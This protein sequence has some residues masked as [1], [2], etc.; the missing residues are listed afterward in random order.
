[1]RER[2]PLPAVALTCNSSILTAIGNDYDFSQ[3]FSRQ[4]QASIG[5]RDCLVGISTSGSSSNVLEALRAARQRGAT[6]IGFTGSGGGE[7][8]SLCDECFAA[9]SKR[10][11]RIQEAH[12]LAWHLICDAVEQRIVR[13][14]GVAMEARA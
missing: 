1:L 8:A 12:L 11:P 7:L 2:R 13:M 5:S 10:T 9:P 3:I 4:V 6:T 14:D